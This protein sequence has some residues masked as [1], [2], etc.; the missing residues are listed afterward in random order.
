M[1]SKKVLA[2]MM[3]AIVASSGMSQMAVQVY[4]HDEESSSSS[5]SCSDSKVTD[6]LNEEDLNIDV[7]STVDTTDIEELVKVEDCTSER[8][9]KLREEESDL[10]MGFISDTYI[11]KNKLV[12]RCMGG[13]KGKEVKLVCFDAEKEFVGDIVVPEKVKIGDEIYSVT[14]IGNAA[15]CDCPGLKNVTLPNSITEINDNAFKYCEN[16]QLASLPTSLETIGESAF[17]SCEN[18][19]LET[20]PDTIFDIGKGAFGCCS[21][22]QLKTLPRIYE[23]KEKTFA[24]CEKLQLTE[25]PSSISKIDSRAFY[26]CKSLELTSLSDVNEIGDFA[27]YNCGKIELKDLPAKLSNIG[28]EAFANCKNVKLET[29]PEE[30]VTIDEGAFKRTGIITI[31][32]PASVKKLGNFAFDTKSI[33]KI[34]L[35][36][37]SRLDAGDIER[38]YGWQLERVQRLGEEKNYPYIVEKIIMPVELNAKDAENS[39]PICQKRFN[40]VEGAAGRLQDGT[41]VHLSCFKEQ[42]YLNKMCNLNTKYV[43]KI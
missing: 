11:S 12:F 31:T 33:A 37:G 7:V 5:C 25:L 15:F 39:C 42:A 14:C 2:L 28:I 27:F 32:I 21:E 16:L 8:I 34:I 26:N 1:N 43:K 10:R 30:L 24:N 3:G 36:Q 9:K 18:L 22:L 19:Q 35:A 41:C 4:A 23:I 40:V 6:V 38:A 13:R 17:E 20:L 29:L